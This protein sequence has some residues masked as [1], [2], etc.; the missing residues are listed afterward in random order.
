MPLPEKGKERPGLCQ[1]GNA[2]PVDPQPPP[3]RP[4]ID[5]LRALAVLL[6]VPFHSALI[7]THDGMLPLKSGEHSAFLSY[8]AGIVSQ[9]HMP[10]LF[11]ISGTGTWFALR[12][13]KPSEY[14]K[15]RARRLLVPLVFGTLAI[16]PPQVYL[17]RVNQGRF[18]GSF[19]AFYP[20]FFDGIYPE[21]NLTYNHLW[22]VAYLFVFSLI[23]LPLF[24]RLGGEGGRRWISRFALVAEKRGGIFLAALPVAVTEATLRAAFPGIQNLV[25]DWANFASYLILFVLGYLLLTDERMEEAV[26]RDGPLALALGLVTT[27]AGV[28]L[29]LTG[30][31][32]GPGYSPA[33][34]SY[35]VLDAFNMWF[36]VVAFLGMGRRLLFFSNRTLRYVTE[37]TYPF[38]IL[39]LTVI[40][41]IGFPV[42]KWEAG[43]SLRYAFVVIVSTLATLLTYDLLVRRWG[44]SRFLFGLKPRPG[45]PG[46]E[47]P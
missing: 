4:D 12:F 36:W 44:V 24:V 22:F 25:W 9:W 19:F 39:H 2:A 6:L 46:D 40:V 47:R 23:A 33:W 11:V 30:L 31:A 45:P 17:E 29:H 26:I 27:S 37:A 7:F 18:E 10:L 42:M 16:I 5:W 15:E 21:G 20:H 32:P 35:M 41:L 3:R 8:F 13:R 38:Y 34:M 14:A 43:V 28:A 1:K